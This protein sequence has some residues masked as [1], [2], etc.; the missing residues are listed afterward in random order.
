MRLRELTV[1]DVT[2]FLPRN[3]NYNVI[4]LRG[5]EISKIVWHDAG[6]VLDETTRYTHIDVINY[7]LSS[8]HISPLGCPFPTVTYYI[9]RD[10]TVYKLGQ[11]KW[12]TWHVGVPKKWVE[13]CPRWNEFCLGI[14]FEFYG[15]KRSRMPEQ[16]LQ[17]GILLS[18]EIALRRNLLANSVLGHRELAGS[19]HVPGHPERIRRPCPGMGVDMTAIRSAVEAILVG[20]SHKTERVVRSDEV[21]SLRI[22]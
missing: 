1:R 12:R 18:A 21:S 3:P 6:V 5:S 17:A 11:E 15:G 13:L 20:C 10:G 4:P 22:L 14:G 9:E 8:N 16:M 2:T 7:D 19:G